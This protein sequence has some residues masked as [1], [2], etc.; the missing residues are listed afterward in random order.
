MNAAQNKETVA[1]RQD[2]FLT[3]LE[4]LL[5]L[6][7][8]ETNKTINQAA[9]LV[10]EVLAADK[11][12][13]F[14]H[15]S[16]NE[17]LVALGTS[18]TTMGRRQHAIGMDRLPLANGGCTVE[19]FLSGTSYITGHAD[20]DPDEL[21]GVK[22]GLGVRSQIATVFQVH[23]RHRGVL[24]AASGTPDFFSQQDLRFLEA[25][26]RWIGILIDRAELVE[27]MR[28][29]A[30]EQGKRLAAE[31][32]LTIMAHDLHNYLTP[33][34]G[35]IELM[36]RRARREGREQDV[37]DAGATIHTLG[38]LEQVITDLLDVA[39]LNQGIFVITPVSMNLVDLVQ[40]VVVAFTSAESPIHVHAP[41][42]V[43][44]SADP[45]RL[46]QGLE[47]LLANAVKYAPRQTVIKVEVHTE[48]RT[49]GLWVILTVSNEGPGLPSE[50]LATLFH[51]FAAGSQ[52]TGLGLGLYLV[53]KIAEAHAGTLTLD[54]TTGQGVQ[55]TLALPVEEEELTVGEQEASP[56]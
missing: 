24:L 25:V 26:A 2:R 33:M 12:D 6:P 36:E 55:A 37:R 41:A 21:V 16:A 15:E 14:F 45:A 39:R 38:L 42:E 22:V 51:P 54:S 8:A 11:V 23:A 56:L 30:V 27:L 32:L 17:T 46:R 49:D 35:R 18:N 47:N 48:K 53:K 10:A 1:Q 5:E 31:E 4:R 19:V 52:S 44:L 43:V 20:Q 34:R 28:H 3:T 13:V 7:A 40:E 9:Q 50:S 29:E